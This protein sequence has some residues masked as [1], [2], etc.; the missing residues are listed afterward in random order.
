MGLL[1]ILGAP[2]MFSVF[3]YWRIR[4]VITTDPAKKERFRGSAGSALD[5]VGEFVL[6]IF[7]FAIVFGIAAAFGFALRYAD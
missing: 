4:S 7:G 5:D 1:V 2:V 3:V 6:I